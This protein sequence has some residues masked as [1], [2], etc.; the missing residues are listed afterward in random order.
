[1]AV[2]SMAVN[3]VPGRPTWPGSNEAQCGHDNHG[4]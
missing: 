1:M 2:K 3:V 4:M